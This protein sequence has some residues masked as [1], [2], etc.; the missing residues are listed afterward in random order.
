M[1]VGNAIAV[2]PANAQPGG[3]GASP[4][5]VI[6]NSHVMPLSTTAQLMVMGAGFPPNQE[7]RVVIS[8]KDGTLSDIGTQMEPT[9]I[10]A[11]EFGVWGAKLTTGRYARS[12][13]ASTEI[14]VLYATD[15][16]YN[17]LAAAPFGY[18]D[19][20]APY[21]DWPSWARAIIPEPEASK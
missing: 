7:V 3:M 19:A 21:S 18:Y 11:N 17:I 10:M 6:E 2:K 13:L 1:A 4:V 8:Q 12:A 15:V 20:K 14:Y 9:E 5:L 16:S